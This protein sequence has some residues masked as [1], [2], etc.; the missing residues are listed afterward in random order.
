MLSRVF[1]R[2]HAKSF[3][4]TCAAREIDRKLKIFSYDSTFL[5][6]IRILESLRYYD[7]RLLRFLILNGFG[8]FHFLMLERPN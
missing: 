6:R 7:P 4:N 1:A 8:F 3:R 5:H 2:R